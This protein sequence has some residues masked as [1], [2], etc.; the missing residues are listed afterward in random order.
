MAKTKQSGKTRQ[1]ATRPGKRRGVKIYGGQVIKTGQII[2]RQ[3]GTKF[4]P[5]SGVGIGRD[6]T[7]FALRDGTVNF[8]VRYGKQLIE[9]VT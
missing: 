2:V 5:G 1:H 6:H 3:K 4:H 7:L 9:V 8:R